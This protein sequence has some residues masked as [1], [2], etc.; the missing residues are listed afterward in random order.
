MHW[1]EHAVWWHVYPLGFT[2]AE[3]AALPPSA[4]P[5]PRLSR[6]TGWLDYL[7][8][9]G[10]NGLALGPVFASET[11]GYDTVDHFRIDPRLG[12]EED[13]IGW[14]TQASRR[15]AAGAARRG[16]QP[17]RPR[18]PRFRRRRRARAA[19]HGTPPG[20]DPAPGGGYVTFEGHDRLVALNHDEPE[21]ADYVTDVMTHWL[22]RGV[23]GW[24]LDAAY[25]VP[26]PFWR[27]VTER[28][29]ADA[30]PTRGSWAR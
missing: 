29:R 25:A 13:C 3:R 1:S 18:L 12:D 27:A 28:V 4:P 9:L 30:S 11:H 22:D 8:A 16:V 21:V 6:L 5:V 10:C 14:S 26:L 19:T 24:R 20:S 2:G 17:R 7:V 15:G 23:D